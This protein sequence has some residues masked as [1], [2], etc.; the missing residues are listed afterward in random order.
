MSGRARDAWARTTVHVWPGAYVFASLPCARMADAAA[1]AAAAPEGTFVALVREREEVALTLPDALR[2]QLD[3]LG[4][5]AA[6]PFRVLTF[7]VA[8]PLDLVGYLAP[9]AVRLAEAGVSIVP[10]CG[11]RTDHLLVRAEDLETAERVLEAF[12]RACGAG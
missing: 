10:Q 2:P 6:G 4:A 9:A 5:R 11:F 12:V 1:L 3:A 7:D 8:L